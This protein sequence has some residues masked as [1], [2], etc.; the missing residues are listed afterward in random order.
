MYLGRQI[1]S[2]IQASPRRLGIPHEQ[3]FAWRSMATLAGRGAR[4][5]FLY[6]RGEVEIEIFASEFGSAGGALAI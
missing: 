5:L 2:T 3:S 1:G 4:V 6:A